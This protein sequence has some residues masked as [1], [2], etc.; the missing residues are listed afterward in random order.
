[1]IPIPESIEDR[2]KRLLPTLSD[3]EKKELENGATWKNTAFS[4][5]LQAKCGWFIPIEANQLEFTT[6]TVKFSSD[7]VPDQFFHDCFDAILKH[8]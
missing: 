2:I 3:D 1:M 6:T 8:K 4:F 5:G 7:N